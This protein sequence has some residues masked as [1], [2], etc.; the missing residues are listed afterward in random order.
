MD[1]GDDSNAASTSESSEASKT[2]PLVTEK[3]T[4]KA[5]TALAA[6]FEGETPK[7]ESVVK[8]ETAG[9]S[10][11]FPR[12]RSTAGHSRLPGRVRFRP[13]V[14]CKIVIV[15]KSKR[16]EKKENNRSLDVSI[17]WS[18][19]TNHLPDG[20]SPA[21]GTSHGFIIRAFANGVSLEELLVLKA[22]PPSARSHGFGGGGV[23]MLSV[24]PLA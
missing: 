8:E 11:I 24:L 20:V 16:S 9:Q 14:R 23:D 2:A 12:R 10:R 1:G 15:T 18:K 22:A 5:L 17:R 4:K 21:P 3:E 19:C 6:V 7:P 13:H